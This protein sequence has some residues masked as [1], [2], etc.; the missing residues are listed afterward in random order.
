MAVLELIKGFIGYGNIYSKK[1]GVNE[2]VITKKSQCHDFLANIFSFI[3]IKRD[4]VSY[5][6]NN[7]NFQKNSLVLP[8]RMFNKK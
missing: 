6:L 4:I 1:G 7:Y 8:E 2:L 3:V 5:V